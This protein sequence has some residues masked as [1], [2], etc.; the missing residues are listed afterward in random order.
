MLDATEKRSLYT[1]TA[2]TL[3]GLG[4]FWLIVIR[5][6]Q[7]LVNKSN[8]ALAELTLQFRTNQVMAK[9]WEHYLEKLEIS[10]NRLQQ[11]E[12]NLPTG[13]IFRWELRAFL[14]PNVAGVEI[15]EAEPPRLVEPLVSGAT[16]YKTCSFVISGSATYH[17]L[18]RFLAD[19]EN[20]FIHLRVQRFELEPSMPDALDTADAEK[21]QFT[22]EF[23]TLAKLSALKQPDGK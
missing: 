10:S 9:N 6:E 1:L 19:V 16:N 18:G 14:H 13:D 22:V 15:T 8:T 5:T 7:N 21:L 20:R 23:L 2:A 12:L 11:L 3:I 17:D 4:L